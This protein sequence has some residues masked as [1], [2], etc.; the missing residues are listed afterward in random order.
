MAH[1]LTK[2][3]ILILMVLNGLFF[4][5]NIYVLGNTQEAIAMHDDLAPTAGA[6]M[7]NAKVL[8]CFVVGMCYLVAAWGIVRRRSIPVLFGVLG[9]ALFDGFY[10]L[11]LVLWGRSHTRVWVDFIIFGGIS[12]VIGIFSW[13]QWKNRIITAEGA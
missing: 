10:L 9:F 8:N 1:K 7:A 5:A 11:E 12:L 6:V 2:T 3:A 13:H 4:I